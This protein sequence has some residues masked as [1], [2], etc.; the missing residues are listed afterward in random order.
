MIVIGG[1]G[2]LILSGCSSKYPITFDSNPQGASLICSNNNY[3]YTPVTL[4]MSEEKYRETPSH[5]HECSANW[6]SGATKNY[7]L[8]SYTE[9]PDGVTQTLQR[10]NIAG[11]EKDAQFALEV[12]NMKYQ[13]IRAEAAY[14]QKR[15]ANAAE[16]NARANQQ[17]ADNAYYQNMNR[18]FQLQNINNYLRYGY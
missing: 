18:N 11:Y 13:R 15:N 12:Q 16:R 9:F 5:M 4:Y 17:A 14:Q 8:F 2:V 3:G 6:V 10:P 7:G 1:L